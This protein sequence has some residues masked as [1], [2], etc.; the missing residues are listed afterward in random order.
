MPTVRPEVKLSDPA[1]LMAPVAHPD[2][3][4]IA[5][6][7][8]QDRLGLGLAGLALSGLALLLLA[9]WIASW[10]RGAAQPK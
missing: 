4:A 7:T 2:L 8:G 6:E 5:A 9:P 3:P 10:F 1:P